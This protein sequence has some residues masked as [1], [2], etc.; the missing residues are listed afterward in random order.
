MSEWGNI[1]PEDLSLEK[2]KIH[3]R[4]EKL[5][6]KLADDQADRKDFRDEL[7]AAF[8]RHEEYFHGTSDKPGLLTRTKELETA[9]GIHSKA[10]WIAVTGLIGLGTKAFWDAITKR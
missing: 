10:T 7:K 2:L 4:L 3:N 9:H 1:K 6:E 5:E 8:K